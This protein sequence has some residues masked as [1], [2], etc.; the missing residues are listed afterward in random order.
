M[1][2]RVFALELLKLYT[3]RVLLSSECGRDRKGGRVKAL[4]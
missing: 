4:F 1:T 2:M 3:M